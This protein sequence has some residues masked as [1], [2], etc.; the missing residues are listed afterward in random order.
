MFARLAS[1]VSTSPMRREAPLGI[2]GGGGGVDVAL[3]CAPPVV[4]AFDV[5]EIALLDAGVVAVEPFDAVNDDDDDAKVVDGT[6]PFVTYIALSTP[7]SCS[8]STAPSN[9]DSD[10]VDVDDAVVVVVVVDACVAVVV[11]VLLALLGA[12]AAAVVVDDDDDDDDVADD[13]VVPFGS[14]IGVADT[15]EPMPVTTLT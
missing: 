4:G 8:V 2:G 9:D 5:D 15:Y 10:V 3:D 1:P 13:V 14:S 12:V 6:G 7:E 11:V